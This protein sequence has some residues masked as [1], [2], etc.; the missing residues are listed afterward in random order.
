M[1]CGNRANRLDRPKLAI[2]TRLRKP[3]VTPQICGTVRRR[4]KFA[5]EAAS[6][7]LLGPGEKAEIP[8]KVDKAIRFTESINAVSPVCSDPLCA[9]QR[10]RKQELLAFGRFYKAGDTMW[11]EQITNGFG[12]PLIQFRGAYSV[13]ARAGI[14][15]FGDLKR[16]FGE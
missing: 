5:P 2:T 1:I 3:T 8:A 9:L 13:E 6:I 10:A 4:P 12:L 7:R 14:A 16:Q 15:H 11:P